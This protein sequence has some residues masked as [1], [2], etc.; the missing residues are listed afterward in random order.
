VP[1][2]EVRRALVT[3]LGPRCS[4]CHERYPFAVD[5]D[6][7]TGLVRGYLC[8]DCNTRVERCVHIRGRPRAE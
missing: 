8:R 5:H 2:A 7:A 6:H 1:L 4:L 3:A